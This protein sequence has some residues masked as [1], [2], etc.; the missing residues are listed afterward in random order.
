[1]QGAGARAGRGHGE[2]FTETAH[3]MGGG[4]F[5][6]PSPRAS[7]RPELGRG[8]GAGAFGD[9][10]ASS[11]RNGPNRIGMHAQR[12]VDAP[13]VMSDFAL[14]GFDFGGQLVVFAHFAGKE[15]AGELGL[16]LDAAGCQQVG[17]AQLVRIAAEIAGFHPALVDQGAQGVVDLA[18]RNAGVAG[19]F[20]LAGL[21]GIRQAPQQGHV[22]FVG[23]LE[24][25][26]H[27]FI[28]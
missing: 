27:A 6:R 7:G 16:G 28:Q 19:Q 3:R 21:R 24:H 18:Q 14:Q 5:A 25:R 23:V 20:A 22:Q 4:A 10:I 1:M 9:A 15:G 13:S 17:I 2:R 11:C 12:Q 8:N 26:R